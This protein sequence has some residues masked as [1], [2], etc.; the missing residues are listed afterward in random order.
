MTRYITHFE[1]ALDG[2]RYEADRIQTMHNGR[3][4]WSRYDLAAIRAHVD[5]D[6]L[7]ARAPEMWRYRELLPVGDEIAPVT[8]GES[9]TPLVDCPNLAKWAGVARVSVKDE[10]RL[11]GA[12]FKPR[13]LSL[14]LTMARH[15]GISRV[16]MSSNG[17]A[18]GAMA[19]YAARAGIDAVIFVP[20]DTPRANIAEAHAAGAAVYMID[21]LIDEGGRQ[22]R[23]GHDRGL[24]FDISTMKEPYRLEGKKTIGLEI[25]E[26]LGWSLPD[27]I[28]YPTGGGTALIGMWKA[29][30]ELRELGWLGDR[31][32]PR[33]VAV[34]STGCQPFVTAIRAGT[35]HCV[36]HENAQT[37]AAG[38]RVPIG[39]GDF[40]VLD[41]VRASGG[42][43]VAVEESRIWELQNVAGRCEGMMLCPESAFCVGALQSLIADG[44]IGADEHALI[45]NTAAG[46]KYMDHLDPDIPDLEL[47]NIDWDEMAATMAARDRHPARCGQNGV[48]QPHAKAVPCP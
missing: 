28:I 26:Q 14:A 20:R 35:K 30:Q 12:S 31:R 1:S 39:I 5:R 17:N 21:G 40:M 25:A 33:L 22:V 4:L 37:L 16:A 19:M 43:A 13:G 3:P 36:R 44:T 32:M 42:T 47:G 2:T 18:G 46:Q 45:V 41:A 23:A 8:L 6:S 10:S 9:I 38:L 11:A 34:Q 24:W 29:F 27:V 15:F 48:A 7:S